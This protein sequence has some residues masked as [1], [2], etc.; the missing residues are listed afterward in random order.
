MDISVAPAPEEAAWILT[1][2]LGRPMG[3]VREETAG[4]FRVVAAG[5]ARETMKTM[6]P[7]PFHSLDAALAEI[8]RF[9]RSQCRR[10]SQ[11]DMSG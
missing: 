2:L 4:A 6:K 1:D 8:E 11:K 9:T 3:R 5:L 7:G 10:V